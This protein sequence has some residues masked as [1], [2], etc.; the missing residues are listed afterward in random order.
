[1]HEGEDRLAPE[2]Q[3]SFIDNR[4]LPEE[5]EEAFADMPVL[6]CDDSDYED[7]PIKRRRQEAIDDV[8][9]QL[10]RSVEPDVSYIEDR[11]NTTDAADVVEASSVVE[12]SD[13]LYEP[14]QQ[15][16][17]PKESRARGEAKES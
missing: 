15:V 7:Q 16:V 8:P 9:H 12:S 10:R 4:I 3:Q 13:S 2:I 17:T 14:K 5:T 1:M 11:V 6:G